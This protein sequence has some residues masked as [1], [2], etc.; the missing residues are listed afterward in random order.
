[1]K[2]KLENTITGIISFFSPILAFVNYFSLIVGGIWLLII[3]QWK[4]A[5][6]GFII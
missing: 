1:M 2:M 3:G 5:I 4:F 6:F